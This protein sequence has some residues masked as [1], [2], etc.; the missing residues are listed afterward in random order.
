MAE[1]YKKYAEKYKDFLD[2][3]RFLYEYSPF[4]LVF[5][6]AMVIL[7]SFLGGVGVVSLVPMLSYSGWLAQNKSGSDLNWLS[8]LWQQLPMHDGQIP[9]TFVLSVYCL[10]ICSVSMTNYLAELTKIKF[11]KNFERYCRESLIQNLV[12][13]RW[14]YLLKSKLKDSEYVLN[15]GLM[16][17]SA[18]TTYTLSLFNNI[19]K[20]SVYLIVGLMLSTGLTVISLIT[21]ISI[22]IFFKKSNSAGMGK[23]EFDLSRS[24]Q[25]NLSNFLE[26]IKIAKIHELT[27]EYLKQE[28]DI[29]FKVMDNNIK[30][31]SNQMKI[32]FGYTAIGAIAFTLIFLISISLLQISIPTLVVL[33]FVYNQIIRR[34]STMQQS[35]SYA[36][37]IS[38]LFRNYL[39][40]KNDFLSNKESSN[41][42][43]FHT[44]VPLP[45]DILIKVKQVSFSYGEKAI[46]KNVSFDIHRNKITAIK[47]PSGVGKSTCVD[48]ILG[49]LK[50]DDGS[51]LFN[52]SVV[53]MDA[54][55]ATSKKKWVSYVPQNIF[56]FNDSIR[57]NITWLNN[58][59]NEAEL[60]KVLALVDAENLVRSMPNGL[61]TMIGDRGVHLSGGERQKLAIARAIL[62]SPTL[63]ILDEA[64]SALDPQSEAVIMQSLA[65]LKQTM[66]VILI[67]HRESTIDYADEII[68]FGKF[69][70]K[71]EYPLNFNVLEDTTVAMY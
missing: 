65:A 15:V 68:D 20:N 7:S 5:S 26:G 61:N 28:R 21:V 42:I 13:A 37:N 35:M 31:L 49:L 8:S 63:L 47:G 51:I 17:I 12:N 41:V 30:F 11:M 64:T 67:A 55:R 16:K 62:S 52:Q 53:P 34:I 71:E 70:L 3:I 46:L 48:L 23:Q 39:I 40:L 24:R 33:L 43:P 60:W 14:E 54:E 44:R 56:L 6:Q 45:K 9:I 4:Q 57:N 32:K 50:P 1:F 2:F 29:S 59:V 66:T 27:Q 69:N 38:P 10:I 25:I 58:D 22:A 36:L 19:I 18:L